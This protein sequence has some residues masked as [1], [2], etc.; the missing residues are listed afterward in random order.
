VSFFSSL[1]SSE[2]IWPLFLNSQ[3]GN[4]DYEEFVEMMRKGI[5]TWE[6][7]S[8]LMNGVV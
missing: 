6:N 1:L 7:L 3:D 8:L 5:Y 2:H 4:I